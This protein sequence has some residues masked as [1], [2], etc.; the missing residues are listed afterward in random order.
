MAGSD[1]AVMLVST[2]RRL[3]WQFFGHPRHQ[4][5]QDVGLQLACSPKPFPA[6]ALAEVLCLTM[7]TC[8][9]VTTAS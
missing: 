6:S 3:W 7:G 1:A 8:T 5:W 2:T 4:L 9:H